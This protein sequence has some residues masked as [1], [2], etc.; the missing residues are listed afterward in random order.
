LNDKLND[1][2]EVACAIPERTGLAD[3]CFKASVSSLQV[4]NEPIAVIT[5]IEEKSRWYQVALAACLV[6]AA[7]VAIR[8]GTQSQPTTFDNKTVASNE[9]L[10]VEEEGLLL[11]DL[12]LSEY[13]YLADTRELAFADVTESFNSL[14]D[15]I[16]LWQHGLFT[17]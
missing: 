17:E 13:T 11:E 8:L 6:F 14:R 5:P 3:R 4:E 9:V 10:S 2:L 16:E 15:D 12:N 7:L 1:Q